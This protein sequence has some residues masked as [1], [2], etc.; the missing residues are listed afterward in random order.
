MKIPCKECITFAICKQKI[1]TMYR[2]DLNNY[3]RLIKCGMLIEYI[4]QAKDDNKLETYKDLINEARIFFN[5]N[6]IPTKK[7][8]LKRKAINEGTL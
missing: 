1:K 4:N 3:S 2:P 8:R 7:E 5:L 6:P